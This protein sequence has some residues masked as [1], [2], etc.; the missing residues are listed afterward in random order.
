MSELWSTNKKVIG[1]MLTH[2][3]S[4]FSEDHTLALKGCCPFKFSR[5][6][7][8][9]QGLLRYMTS[10]TIFYNKNLKIGPKFS[11]NGANGN[12]LGKLV[13]VMSR[14]AGIKN[15]VHVCGGLRPKNLVVQETCKIRHDF[16]QLL[17]FIANIYE[18]DWDVKNPKYKWS[19]TTPSTLNEK[20]SE[21]LSTSKKVV[22]AHI[23]PP[24]T[25]TARAV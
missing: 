23:Y 19:I 15:Y 4:T 18:T 12:N 5:A 6:I 25:N 3:R 9:G 22:C 8:S 11:A 21:L 24:K 13:H 10:W 20:I 7:Y 16:G 2:S 1:C 17:I 14:A